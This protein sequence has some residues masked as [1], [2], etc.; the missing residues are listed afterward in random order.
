MCEDVQ[1]KLLHVRE[2]DWKNKNNKIRK[3]I[4]DFLKQ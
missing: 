3:Q 2:T 1:I 4:I